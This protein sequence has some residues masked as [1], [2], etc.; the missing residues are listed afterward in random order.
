MDKRKA[1][2]KA[3]L[4]RGS[5]ILNKPAEAASPLDLKIQGKKAKA[6]DESIKIF[7]QFAITKVPI[8]KSDLKK[9]VETAE[10]YKTI[11]PLGSLQALNVE[12]NRKNVSQIIE[13][14]EPRITNFW[15]SQSMVPGQEDPLFKVKVLNLCVKV[16]KGILTFPD[17]VV[18][19]TQQF[20]DYLSLVEGCKLYIWNTKVND[21]ASYNTLPLDAQ[22]ERYSKVFERLCNIA[23][24]PISKPAAADSEGEEGKE[25]KEDTESGAESGAESTSEGGASEGGSAAA[26]TEGGGEAASTEA[27]AS[28]PSA[29]ESGGETTEGFLQDNIDFNK[30]N[31][32]DYIYIFC[33]VLFIFSLFYIYIR[34]S[35]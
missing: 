34:Y 19:K 24:V 4:K 13:Y 8:R 11:L 25:G 22:K 15:K 31:N 1:D 21:C 3:K 18:S 7:S 10:K 9:I 5:S 29:G 28:Q 16:K 23:N 12:G 2:A 14:I 17:S 32:S 35:K 20:N 30:L 26:S 33:T 6:M 27:S